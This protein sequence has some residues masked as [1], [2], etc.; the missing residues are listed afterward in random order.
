MPLDRFVM[1]RW[2]PLFSPI[3]WLQNR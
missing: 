3:Y 1:I 2:K